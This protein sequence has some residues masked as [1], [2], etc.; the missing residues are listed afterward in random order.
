MLISDDQYS[1]AGNGGEEE[2]GGH[3]PVLGVRHLPH[4]PAYCL[5]GL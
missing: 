5:L 3:Q 4:P 1:D 2:R